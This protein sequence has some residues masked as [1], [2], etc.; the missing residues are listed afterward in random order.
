M[1]HTR[2]AFTLVELLVVISI[3]A[4]LVAMLVP[5]MEQAVYEAKIASCAAQLTGIVSGANTYALA[6]NN[7]YPTPPAGRRGWTNAGVYTADYLG[8][9]DQPDR[10]LRL[11]IR[12]HIPLKMMLCP[13]IGQQIDPTYEANDASSLVFANYGLHFSR[14]FTDG[15]GDGGLMRVNDRLGWTDAAADPSS[16]P[17]YYFRVV[18]SDMNIYH[19]TNNWAESSHP[20]LGTSGMFASAYQNTPAGNQ[21]YTYAR[22]TWLNGRGP[23]DV[24]FTL[25]DGST[26]VYRAVSQKDGRLRRVPVASNG[27]VNGPY[28][29]Y[30]PVD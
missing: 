2:L 18:A 19:E 16:P 8:R 21:Q 29:F 10:D 27:T 13:Q 20:Q 11:I 15:Y 25:T 24:N 3:I 4:L 23:I 12:D 22:W 30:L 9:K 26:H 5:A 28:Y 17:T 1:S 14:E 6:A 7:H